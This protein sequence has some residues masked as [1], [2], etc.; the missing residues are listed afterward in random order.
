MPLKSEHLCFVCKQLSTND[1]T[2]LL[3]T[4]ICLNTETFLTTW[5]FFILLTITSKEV[6]KQ[7]LPQAIKIFGYVK[8]NYL[9]TEET[10]KRRGR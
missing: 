8:N 7:T 2:K 6:I 4:L 10:N 1:Q 9:T 3:C 5:V